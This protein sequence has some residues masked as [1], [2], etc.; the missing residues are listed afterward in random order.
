NYYIGIF[1][2]C[3]LGG[4]T[5][6]L[7]IPTPQAVAL[8]YMDS[9][10]YGEA[11]IRYEQMLKD[12]DETGNVI[13]PLAKIYEKEGQTQKAIGLLVKYIH[14]Q[15]DLK[16]ARAV[17]E[18]IYQNSLKTG[19]YINVLENLA[20]L[21]SSGDSLAELSNWYET[22]LQDK[23]QVE[24]LTKLVKQPGYRLNEQ[25]YNKLI[26]YYSVNRKYERSSTLIKE[27]VKKAENRSLKESM[28]FTVMMLVNSEHYRQGMELAQK[29]LEEKKPLEPYD[30]EQLVS[31]F[32][33]AGR[34]DMAQELLSPYLKQRSENVNLLICRY[35]IDLAEGKEVRLLR[36]LRQDFYSG[37]QKSERLLEFT[38]NMALKMEDV[39]LTR[40]I[41]NSLNV[42]RLPEETIFKCAFFALIHHDEKLAEIL[43]AKLSPEL[44][45]LESCLNYIIWCTLQKMTVHEMVLDTEKSKILND[46]DKTELAYILYQNDFQQEAFELIRKRP[47]SEVFPIF[48]IRDLVRLIYDFGNTAQMIKKYQLESLEFE[49]YSRMLYRDTE[50]LMAA[51]AGYKSIMM[52][53]LDE[54]KDIPLESLVSAYSQAITYKQYDMAVMLGKTLQEKNKDKIFEYLTASAMVQAG[55]YIDALV[56]LEHL[57]N[58]MR[59][60]SNLFLR[61]GALSIMKYGTDSLPDKT[62]GEIKLE[63]QKIISNRNSTNTELKSAALCLAALGRKQHAENLYLELC[64]KDAMNNGDIDEFIKVCDKSPSSEVKEWF[65]HRA[66]NELINRWM[67]LDRLNRLGLPEESIRIVEQIYKYNQISYLAE[68][69]T[70]LDMVGKDT[71]IANLISSYTG[72]YRIRQILKSSVRERV[73]LLSF[74]NEK[75]PPIE[76]QSP[77]EELLNAGAKIAQKNPDITVQLTEN[78]RK[79]SVNPLPGFTRVPLEPEPPAKAEKQDIPVRELVKTISASLTVNELI[80]NYPP[81]TIAYIYAS[82]GIP[83]LGLEKFK[84]NGAPEGKMFDVILFL[85]AYSGNDKFVEDYLA[86]HLENPEKQ[87]E[88]LYMFLERGRHYDLVFQVAERMYKQYPTLDNRIRLGRALIATKQYQKA[89]DLVKS[90]AE[91]LKQARDIFM[92][93]IAGISSLG[94]FSKDSPEANIFLHICDLILNS[95]DS[96]ALDISNTAFALSNTG[97]YARAKNIFYKLAQEHNTTRTPFL[98]QFLYLSTRVPSRQDF[99]KVRELIAS[100]PPNEEQE[101]VNML[102]SLHMYGHIMLLLKLRHGKDIP[103]KYYP[104]FMYSLLNSRMMK[105]FKMYC[106]LLPPPESFSLDDRISLFVTLLMARENDK[107]DEFLESL[108]GHTEK[109]APDLIRRLAYELANNKQYSKAISLFFMLAK[110]EVNPKSDDIKAM[111]SLMKNTPAPA[112]LSWIEAQ[113]Q[114][115]RNMVQVE[116]MR[117]LVFLDKPEAVINIYREQYGK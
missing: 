23:S 21:S 42:N 52:Q 82:G 63:L 49:P 87:L 66:E 22:T 58:K 13:I 86:S 11:R 41:T 7:L 109:I 18:V 20:S 38:L 3:C 43:K 89:V 39:E 28:I 61:A 50:L 88:Q 96:T 30:V 26:L 25:D 70:A 65:I 48:K 103:M 45:R 60:A 15:P 117:H 100:S 84:S 55:S 35:R 24:I 76:Q 75:Y 93:G 116:W 101:V 79:H 32:I 94:Q 16:D 107:A 10:Q 72:K 104:V 112:I 31:I 64:R 71:V 113:A 69:L 9:G 4:V 40:D 83:E 77:V 105:E 47:G 51:A 92:A 14:K 115:T 5:A 37:N 19:D 110:R 53:L 90:D 2:L 80:S 81:A 57:R 59:P 8:M 56:I 68:Y 46:D 91:S 36:R 78:S 6:K 1:I 44:M 114:T 67:Q 106:K 74:L 73:S 29:Y 97:Y 17:L 62:L 95:P 108:K 27:L 102:A 85:Y 34:A 98:K 33:D 12:G 111:I 54:Y 99:K